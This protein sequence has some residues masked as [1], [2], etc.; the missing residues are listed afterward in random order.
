MKTTL[1]LDDALYRQL[2]AHAALNGQSVKAVLTDAIIRLL[3][4]ARPQPPDPNK[5]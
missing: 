4:S 2:K 5:D 3:A 1:D